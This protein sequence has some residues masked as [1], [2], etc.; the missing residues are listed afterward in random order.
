MNRAASEL[1]KLAAGKPKNF[2]DAELNR[3]TDRLLKAAA[4]ARKRKRKVANEKADALRV[5]T[6]KE[7]Q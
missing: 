7:N 5:E 6:P 4:A 3:R 2:S 1:G